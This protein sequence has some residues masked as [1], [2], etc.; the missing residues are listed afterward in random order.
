MFHGGGQA[1]VVK[2]TVA[3]RNFANTSRI[4]L[5][6]S[7]LQQHGTQHVLDDVSLQGASRRGVSFVIPFLVLLHVFTKERNLVLFPVKIVLSS[8]FFFIVVVV[9]GKI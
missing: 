8:H 6:S 2:L 7:D 1:D 9:Y 5:C 4:T 3:F